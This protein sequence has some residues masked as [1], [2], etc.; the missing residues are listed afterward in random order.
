[1]NV[2][3]ISAVIPKAGLTYK[4]DIAIIY[5]LAVWRLGRLC[6]TVVLLNT[7]GILYRS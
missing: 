4:N 1:M 2:D 7:D 6:P 5:A 3:I